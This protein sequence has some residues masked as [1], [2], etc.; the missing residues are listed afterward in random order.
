[1]HDYFQRNMLNSLNHRVERC[2]P[3]RVDRVRQV[4]GMQVIET[5]HGEFEARFIIN[6]P[7]LGVHFTRMIDDSIHAGPNAVLAFKGEGYRKTASTGRICLRPT[8]SRVFGKLAWKYYRDGMMEI[9]RSVSKRFFV[10]SLQQLIPEVTE[11]DLIGTHSGVR[12]Q[13]LIPDGKLVDIF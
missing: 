9:V 6:F 11:D 1:M 7:F 13:G 5:S 2:K 3:A 10:K 4:N 12:A 8:R